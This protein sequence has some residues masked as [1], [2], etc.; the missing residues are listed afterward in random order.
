MEIT[1]RRTV[2]PS[3]HIAMCDTRPNCRR[4]RKF[5]PHLC[6]LYKTRIRPELTAG[7]L[8]AAMA[9]SKPYRWTHST[10]SGRPGVATRDLSLSTWRGAPKEKAPLRKPREAQ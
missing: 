6:G 5:R 7:T 10:R 8:L 2:T 3:A 4:N 1:P 9:L